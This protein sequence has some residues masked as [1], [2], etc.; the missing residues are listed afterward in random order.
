MMKLYHAQDTGALSDH[1][2]SFENMS[3]QVE[4]EMNLVRRVS[5]CR[6]DSEVIP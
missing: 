3:K 6:D 4:I 1:K 2:D 5:K